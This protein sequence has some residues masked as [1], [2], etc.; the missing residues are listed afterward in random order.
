MPK[1]GG[2]DQGFRRCL[3]GWNPL[4]NGGTRG[5]SLGGTLGGTLRGN[6]LCSSSPG[7]TLGG[8]LGGTLGG[9]FEGNPLCRGS[10][11]L[12]DRRGYVAAV[13]L[14]DGAVG[15]LLG[16]RLSRF[17]ALNGKE[18]ARLLEVK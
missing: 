2:L 15:L 16:V 1:S 3:G 5:G 14:P 13:A 12:C 4:W 8:A 9:K 11:P 18:E 6:P 7:G 10:S 17:G